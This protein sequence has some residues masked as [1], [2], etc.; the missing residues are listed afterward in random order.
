MV[1]GGAVRIGKEISLN[2][3]RQG[4]DIALHYNSS[5]KEA[6]TTKELILETGAGCEIFRCD[7]S[8]PH[9]AKELVPEVTAEL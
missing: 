2:L 4:Y 8:S 5:E 1:T 3:A 6:L 7:L 9:D